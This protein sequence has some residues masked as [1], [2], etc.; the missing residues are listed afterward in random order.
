VLDRDGAWVR[1]PCDVAPARPVAREVRVAAPHGADCFVCK[2]PQPDLGPAAVASPNVTIWRFLDV[3]EGRGGGVGEGLQ[4]RIQHAETGAFLACSLE[5]GLLELRDGAGR[6]PSSLFIADV[7]EKSGHFGLE[8]HG[9][10]GL[11]SVVTL[12]PSDGALHCDP[13]GSASMRERAVFS[14]TEKLRWLAR[15]FLRFAVV[16]QSQD[17]RLQGYRECSVGAYDASPRTDS[18]ACTLTLGDREVGADQV[19]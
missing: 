3:E 14:P 6:E 19:R 15:R 2:A 13:A 10:A 17:L 5:T 7:D 18:Y 4:V 11:A 1:S 16:A 9:E 12:D 8:Q